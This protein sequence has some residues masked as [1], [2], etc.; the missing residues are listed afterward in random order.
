MTGVVTDS[1]DDAVRQKS[2]RSEGDGLERIMLA[3]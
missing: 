1:F 3:S 2:L